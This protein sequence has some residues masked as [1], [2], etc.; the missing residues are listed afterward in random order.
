[1]F[2]LK[3]L[4]VKHLTAPAVFIPRDYHA[5][6]LIWLSERE[7][8]RA[9]GLLDFQDAVIGDPAYDLASLL[10]DARRD[11]SQATQDAVIAHFTTKTGVDPNAFGTA[12]ALC[13]AQRN[14]RI[15]GIFTR[16]S[17]QFGKGHY[18]DLMPRV[19][20]D[21]TIAL[22]HPEL[23]H[24]KHLFNEIFMPPTPSIIEKIKTAYAP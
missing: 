20:R 1:M 23:A 13:S 7:G 17:V 22:D 8:V 24:I 6:N 14:M 10:H 21:L 16:L 19:W 12:F 2:T 9:V 18:A 15:I 5:E 11:V 3:T 4:L